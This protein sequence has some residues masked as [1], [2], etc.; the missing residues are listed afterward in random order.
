MQY[1]QRLLIYFSEFSEFR[2]YLVIFVIAL[3]PTQCVGGVSSV[4]PCC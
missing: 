4:D 1:L 2:S 3:S